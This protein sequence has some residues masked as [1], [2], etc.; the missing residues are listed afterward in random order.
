MDHVTNGPGRP[1]IFFTFA[2]WFSLAVPWLG[3]GLG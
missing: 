3:A 1:R 2:G